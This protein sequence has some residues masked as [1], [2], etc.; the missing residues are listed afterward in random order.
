MGRKFKTGKIL[1]TSKISYSNHFNVPTANFL[2][3]IKKTDSICYQFFMTR[4]GFEP[5]LPP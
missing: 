5:V 3:S 4:T 2:K 1:I